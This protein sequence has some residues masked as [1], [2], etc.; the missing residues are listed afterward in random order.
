MEQLGIDWNLQDFTIGLIPLS[1]VIYFLSI[2]GLMLYLNLVVISR[3]HWSR[4]QQVSLGGQF[5]IRIISLAVALLAFNFIINRASSSLMTRLDLTSEKLY[6]LDASTIDTLTTARNK[7]RP[8]TVQ[9]FVSREVPREY[10]STKKQF[11][12]LLRQFQYYGGNN[13]SVR[14]VDVLPNSD[15]ELEA[16]RLGIETPTGS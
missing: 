9:A 3:R 15:A 10:V 2:I 6:T 7:N 12:G 1:N 8:V 5:A 14:F 4:G 11:N 16:Q 13:V